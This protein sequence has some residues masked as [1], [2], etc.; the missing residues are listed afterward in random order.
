VPAQRGVD[1]VEDRGERDRA[2][3]ALPQAGLGHRGVAARLLLEQA[4]QVLQVRLGAALDVPGPGI[5]ASVGVGQ[6]Q[7]R[8]RGDV[9]LRLQ[10]VV[11]ALDGRRQLGAARV[12][13]RH[14]DE[15]LLR[16]L[17]ERLGVEDL[18]AQ[19]P[20]PVAPV[21]AREL[22][23][24]VQALLLRERVG[25]REVGQPRVGGLRVLGRLRLLGGGGA[26]E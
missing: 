16:E 8:E 14:E 11:L 20:A 23:Q 25:G 2:L 17:E 22:E 15:V 6:E 13:E 5:G 26:E 21:G 12:V 10:L 3:G 4:R 1:R 7:R 18:A 24:H 9:E 19:A